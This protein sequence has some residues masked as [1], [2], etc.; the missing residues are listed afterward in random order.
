MKLWKKDFAT[1][2]AFSFVWGSVGLFGVELPASA[3]VPY[4]YDGT[5][6]DLYYDVIDAV[7]IRITGCEKEVTAVEIPAKIAGKP[8]TS[9]GRSAF[10]GCNKSGAAIA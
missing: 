2:L 4:F 8:V 9:V 7:E 6:G 10:S 5:Y 1:W 3:D